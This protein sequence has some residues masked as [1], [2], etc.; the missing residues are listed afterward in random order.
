MN[1]WIPFLD[2]FN[3]IIFTCIC[4]GFIFTKTGEDVCF[5]ARE[6]GA[7][8]NVSKLELRHSLKCAMPWVEMLNNVVIQ[9]KKT[10][11]GRTKE[12]EAL[13][14]QLSRSRKI[15]QLQTEILPWSAPKPHRTPLHQFLKLM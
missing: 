11:L 2:I 4:L 5:S 7:G 9:A 10:K 12:Y 15:P 1:V 13:C 8:K 3:L 6:I 14:K